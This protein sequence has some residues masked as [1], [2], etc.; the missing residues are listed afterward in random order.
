MSEGTTPSLKDLVDDGL[1]KHVGQLLEDSWKQVVRCEAQLS[2]KAVKFLE[3]SFRC[4]ANVTDAHGG[5]RPH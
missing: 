4:K 3:D 2:I 1:G 5:L